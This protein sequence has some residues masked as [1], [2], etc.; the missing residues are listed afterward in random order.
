MSIL[1]P[2]SQVRLLYCALV[3][4]TSCVAQKTVTKHIEITV[5]KK[6]SASKEATTSQAPRITVWVHGTKLF[7]PV[8]TLVHAS[9]AGLH[10]LDKVPKKHRLRS[11]VASLVQHAPDR[12]AP[13]HCYL[14][15]WSGKLCFKKRKE[16]AATLYSYLKKL[17]DTYVA[18]YKVKPEITVIT[19]SHGGN[20]VLNMAHAK[21]IKDDLKLNVVLLACP[22]QHE[23]KDL[24]KD[25]LFEKVYA[26]Y[27]TVDLLQII[28][29]QGLYE[30]AGNEK[31]HMEFS[32]REFPAHTNVRQ[33]E[34][35]INGYGVSHIGFTSKK[36][37]RLLPSLLEE[38][39]A[40]EHDSPATTHVLQVTVTDQKKWRFSLP[41]DRDRI[42]GFFAKLTYCGQKC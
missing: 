28:D 2:F 16:E 14:F 3:L 11:V 38:L 29:P 33:A 34:V 35:K 8:S 27:S 20:V 36:F 22:V 30:T 19:H 13:A 5:T 23:T 42:A 31:K 12:F 21:S 17:N 15:G 1:K 32:E 37:M 18:Q 4:A 26:L 24:V 6:N 25:P 40:W 41:V 9:P 10:H 39:E 7:G